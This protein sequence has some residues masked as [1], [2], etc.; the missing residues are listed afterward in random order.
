MNALFGLMKID[1]RD[2]L[3]IMQTLIAAMVINNPLFPG[4]TE[5]RSWDPR[6]WA[7]A[8]LLHVSI[9]EPAFYWAHR[10]LHR[11][12]LLSQYHAMHHSSPVTQSLTGE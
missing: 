4:V 7:V 5:L 12:P 6:G 2:N 8:L 10:A 11:G 3:V 1:R 9:S